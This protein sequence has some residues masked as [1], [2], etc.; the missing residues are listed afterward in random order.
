MSI[1]IGIV[2]PQSSVDKIVE[3]IVE[4]VMYVEPIPLSYAEFTDAVGI[5]QECQDTLDC[6]LFS[7]STPYRYVSHFLHATCPWEYLPQSQL[8]LVCSLLQAAYTMGWDISRA[9]FDSYA[10]KLVYSAYREIGYERD[11][12]ELFFAG[13]ELTDPSYIELLCQFHKQMYQS[14][15]AACCI[16]GIERVRMHL[17]DEKIPCIIIRNATEVIVQQVN[18]LRLDLQIKRVDDAKLAAVAIEIIYRGEHSAYSQSMLQVFYHKSSVSEQIYM[19]AQK[20]GAAVIES[21][22]DC[23]YLFTTKAA[24]QNDTED[25]KR[26]DLLCNL[27]SRDI[28]QNAFI[29]VGLGSDA[30][31]SQRNAD[32]ARRH[33]RQSGIDSLYVMQ[34]NR[35][36]IGPITV[37]AKEDGRLVDEVLYRISAQTGIGIKALS[38]LDI[39]LRQYQVKDTT[40]RALAEMYGV[41]MR[42]MNRILLKLEQAGYLTVV[43]K[44]S[45]A[46]SGRPGRIMRINIE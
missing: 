7:G 27:L 1:K 16:T 33:A 31:Q 13:F 26:F 12:T 2:G 8:S 41:N 11:D 5:L 18:K 46:T 6:L 24:I 9:S 29:G 22:G 17:L 32:A 19:Y 25:F 10:E 45:T 14:G 23:V 38:R 35:R 21:S 43:G 42:S 20:L 40:A 36:M 39:I 4:N 28:V 44:E 3:A 15:K 34:E 30:H 37:S